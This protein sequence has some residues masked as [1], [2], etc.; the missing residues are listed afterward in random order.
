MLFRSVSQSRYEERVKAVNYNNA[1]AV[2]LAAKYKSEKDVNEKLIEHLQ[3]SIEELYA[4][5]DKHN[6]DK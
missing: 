5:A 6:W 3:A 4:L 2:A 1:V